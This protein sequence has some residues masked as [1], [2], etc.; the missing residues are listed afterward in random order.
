MIIRKGELRKFI[1]NNRRI[2][3]ALLRE[4]IPETYTI[5]KNPE[6][7]VHE[8]FVF[9]NFLQMNYE[10]IMPVFNLPEFSPGLFPFFVNR[11]FF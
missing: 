6:L 11:F 5:V 2:Q 1:H 4:R 9:A 8:A 3:P 10:F 7:Y